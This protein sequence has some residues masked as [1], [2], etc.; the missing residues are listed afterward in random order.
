MECNEK[1]TVYRNGLQYIKIEPVANCD[2]Q[3]A[4]QP[5][6]DLIP[7]PEVKIEN[8]GKNR[9]KISFSSKNAIAFAEIADDNMPVYGATKANRSYWEDNSNFAVFNISVQNFHPRKNTI[10]GA[11]SVS[12]ASSARWMFDSTIRWPSYIGSA[13]PLD[14]IFV[15]EDLGVEI[16]RWFLS[17]PKKDVDKAVLKIDLPGFF[18]YTLPLNKVVPGIGFGVPG[19]NTPAMSVC[20]Q[21]YQILQVPRLNLKRTS[22]EKEIVPHSENAIHH[23]QVFSTD[24]KVWRSSP[25][26]K[27]NVSKKCGKLKVFSEKENKP[28]TLEVPENLIPVYR[29]EYTPGIGSA[30]PCSAGRRFAGA[31]G[32]YPAQYSGRLGARRDS[33]VFIA[34]RDF[35]AKA[36]N[37]TVDLLEKSWGFSKAGQHLALPSGVISRRAAFTLTMDLKQTDPAGTQ[38]ILDNRSSQPGLLKILSK[39]GEIYVE[40]VDDNLKYYRYDTGLILPQN[41]WCKLVLDYDLDKFTIS[42]DNEKFSSYR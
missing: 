21:D 33:T 36:Q 41:K 8:T 15:K 37:T 22:F 3:F 13:V 18:D 38:T 28:I 9:Y 1:T 19:K 27:I 31:A 29:Y 16:C 25:L 23:F 11:L 39:D 34:A 32:G 17:I 14:K 30:L 7:D 2:Y 10:K 40:F 12:G 5:L 42:L 20:R 6:R 26:N 24:N 4:K 35:P